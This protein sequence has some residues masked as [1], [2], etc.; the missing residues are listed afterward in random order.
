MGLRDRPAQR[1][2]ACL[3]APHISRVL[4]PRA[5]ASRPPPCISQELAALAAHQAHFEALR[6]AE[7][8]AAQRMEAAERRR[9]E[10]KERRL[11]QAKERAAAE[12]R[13]REK[14][15]AQTFARSYV[16][17][18]VSGAFDAL[19][20]K[21]FFYDPLAREVETKFLPWLTDN[22]VDEL[23][24][25]PAPPRPPRPRVPPPAGQW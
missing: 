21:G 17:G 25:R 13:L 16:S 5:A 9:T 18:L 3:S 2:G 22:V 11:A 20:Q 4:T 7:L 1:A 8:A 10:E 6:N 24:A 14:I 12:K 19:S 23:Q 15:A